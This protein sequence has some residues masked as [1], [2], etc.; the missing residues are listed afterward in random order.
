MCYTEQRIVDKTSEGS[1]ILTSASPAG[2]IAA[3]CI[4][5]SNRFESGDMVGGMGTAS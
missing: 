5:R 1:F 2:S 3:S 4:S